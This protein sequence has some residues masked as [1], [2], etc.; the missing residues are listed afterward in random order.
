MLDRKRD[1]VL[2]VKSIRNLSE[3][4]KRL[5]FNS[6]DLFDFKKSD[7]GGYIKL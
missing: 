1:R 7:V 2:E 6:S 4:L 5:T 3:N